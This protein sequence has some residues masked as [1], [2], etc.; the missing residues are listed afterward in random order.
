MLNKKAPP[1]GE[2]GGRGEIRTLGT[3]LHKAFLVPHHRPLGHSSMEP[4]IR[5][6]RMTICLQNRS[7]TPELKRHMVGGLGLEP[8]TY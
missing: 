8:R 1:K 6:E 5:F 3:S 7:S 4:L 2:A